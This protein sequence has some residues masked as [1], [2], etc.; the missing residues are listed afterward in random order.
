MDSADTEW[1]WAIHSTH[2]KNRVFSFNALCLRYNNGT[3][4]QGK[5]IAPAFKWPIVQDS[6][7]I[8]A[9][10]SFANNIVI[11]CYERIEAQFWL[12]NVTQRLHK[13]YPTQRVTGNHSYGF[14]IW[15]VYSSA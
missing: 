14:E 12:R 8:E 5:V 15:Y 9:E 11:D 7:V 6:V 10:S 1:T 2:P 4:A 3:T 13:T